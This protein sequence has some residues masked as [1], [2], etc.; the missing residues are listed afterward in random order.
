MDALGGF[1]VRRDHEPAD[2]ALDLAARDL[3]S[4]LQAAPA[5]EIELPIAAPMLQQLRQARDLG[6]GV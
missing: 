6:S 1:I 5:L 4:V 3:E 2:Q